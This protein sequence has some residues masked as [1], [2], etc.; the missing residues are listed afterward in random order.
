MIG[1]MCKVH[2]TEMLFDAVQK[3]T[4]VVGVSSVDKQHRFRR[5]PREAA[6]LPLYDAGNCGMQRG[7]VHGVMA[8]PSF[9]LAR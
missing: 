7:R 3:C 8:D 4:Q 2:C 9:S 1:A 5:Y 6:V